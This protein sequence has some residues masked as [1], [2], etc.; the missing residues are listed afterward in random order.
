M[1]VGAEQRKKAGETLRSWRKK[2]DLTGVEICTQLQAQL[3]SLRKATP[4]ELS[5]WET[6]DKAPSGPFLR[7]LHAIGAP[8]DGW[9]GETAPA[10]DPAAEV[11]AMLERGESLERVYAVAA[12]LLAGMV[13]RGLTPDKA[14]GWESLTRMLR[15]GARERG[16][17]MPLEQHPDWPRVIEL[18]LDAVAKLPGGSAAVLGAVRAMSASSEAA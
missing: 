18:V 9:L 3:G 14:R 2:Q 5:R 15:E 13:S 4:A 8:T 11:Q 10:V 17:I 7:A 6:G 16:K 1:T 12:R